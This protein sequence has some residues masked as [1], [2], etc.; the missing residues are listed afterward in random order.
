MDLRAEINY[1][2]DDPAVAYSLVVDPVFRGE[3]CEATQ[4]LDYDVAV[5]EHHDGGATVTV[6][7]VMSA[8]VAD[9]VKRF[10]GETV[11]IVQTEEWGAPDVSGQRTADLRIKIVGQPATMNGTLQL[12]LTGGS[13][14]S[15]ISGEVKVA[16]PF[17]GKKIEPE[18]AKAILGA[19]RQ[20]QRCATKWLGG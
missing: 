6:N 10:I 5:E 13:V 3:V 20:E 1:P 19:I 14:T 4:A 8:D 12:T 15:L 7:R 2:T 18:I 17:F 9:A 11:E 16:V